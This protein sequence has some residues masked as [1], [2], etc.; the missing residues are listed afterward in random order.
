M[1]TADLY[2]QYPKFLEDQPSQEMTCTVFLINYIFKNCFACYDGRIELG[3]GH[4]AADIHSC[5]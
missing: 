1:L 2:R 5:Q 3:E 4:F